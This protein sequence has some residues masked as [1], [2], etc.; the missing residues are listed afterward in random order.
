MSNK[1]DKD[2]EHKVENISLDDN[3]IIKGNNLLALHSLKKQYAGK[4]KL[5]YIDPPYNTGSDSFGYN[6]SF[7]HS[8]WLTFMKNRL[9]VARELLSNDGVIAIH[10]DYIEDSYTKVLS[11]EIFGSD[12]F[13]NIISVRDSHP[14]G[15]KLSAKNKK[16][17][18][19]KSS[20]LIY[21]KTSLLRLN[22]IYQKREDWDTHFNVF[23][24][25]DDSE[26]S[27]ISLSSYI[28]EKYNWANFKLDNHSLK[29]PE[30]KKFA[31]KNRAKIFQS[32]KEIPKSGKELSLNNKDAVV[33]YKKGGYAFNGRRLSPLTKSIH[34][35]GF[36]GYVEEDFAKLLCDFWDDMDFN[37][38][39]N[40]GG[41]HFPSGKKPELLLA[42]I[43][44]MFTNE[45]DI[46]LDY[47][48]GSGTTSAVALKMKRKFIGIEQLDYNEN[49][50]VVRLNNVIKGDKSGISKSVGWQGGGSFTYC[51]LTQHNANIIDKIEQADT[52]E[53]LKSIWQEIE[54]TDFISYKIKPETINKNIHEFEALTIEEQKQFL[55]AVLDKNQL[56]VNYSEIEDEDYQIS[57]KDK[58]L[59]KQFYGE[60]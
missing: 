29:N 5:I 28:K 10:C 38:S 9:E 42:R 37:N 43:L 45:G 58:K 16:I 39:Q 7:N 57:D 56:Y 41:V 36:D 34:S 20:I 19:T 14:S 25:T 26:L 60:G 44:T 59:N 55:I 15:L 8:T 50:S 12:N 46:V 1:Y 17:I 30:F 13:I 11:D 2:G 51:E 22:P 6:D 18:K 54:K 3:L 40:E 35:I 27:K 32:T 52:T 33:E 23:I 21:K 48:L 31:F 47:H 24:N 53:A 4:V 49:D